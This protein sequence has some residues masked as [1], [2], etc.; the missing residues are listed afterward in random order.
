MAHYNKN[1]STRL[2]EKLYKRRILDG[3]LIDNNDA[4]MQEIVYTV[5]H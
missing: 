5:T 3:N 4:V 2:K 1:Y